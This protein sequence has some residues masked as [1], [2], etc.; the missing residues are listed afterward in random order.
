MK[1]IKVK[2]ILVPVDFSKS[3]QLALLYARK[4]TRSFKCK[5]LVL[6]VIYDPPDNPGFY[7]RG[8]D[9]GELFNIQDAAASMMKKFLKGGKLS[10]K[11]LHEVILEPGLPPTRIV[12][13]AQLKKVDLIVMASHA[14]SLKR[15][16]LG[17]T[18]EK[19]LRTAACPVFVVN[20]PGRAKKQIEPPAQT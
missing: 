4:L 6:H 18:T 1:Q 17:S 20:G 14:G 9:P 12:E 19:V 7:S 2:R 10:K 13:I 16:F 3:S 15:F 11:K 8:A 5:L